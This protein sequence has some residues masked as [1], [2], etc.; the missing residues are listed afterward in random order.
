MILLQTIRHATDALA[1]F[2]RIH[3]FSL[4]IHVFYP[5][6]TVE[7]QRS[8]HDIYLSSCNDLESSI[9]DEQ[10]QAGEGLVPHEINGLLEFDV[11]LSN[12]LIQR[13]VIYK[14][15]THGGRPAT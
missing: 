1:Y 12:T 10:R 13:I 7:D 15:F 6:L 2:V 5:T 8:R 14:Y 3:F 9:R 4:K 11:L